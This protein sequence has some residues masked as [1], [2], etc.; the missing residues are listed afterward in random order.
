MLYLYN[1]PKVPFCKIKHCKKKNN[2]NK[3]GPKKLHYE[4]GKLDVS[5]VNE[6]FITEEMKQAEHSYPNPPRTSLHPAH[7]FSVFLLLHISYTWDQVRPKQPCA[8][9]HS[10]LR[11]DF[12][13]CL[14][15]KP[16]ASS[17]G[18]RTLLH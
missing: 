1:F 15:S 17:H 18:A 16:P 5:T 6:K 13:S 8:A 3:S 14:C 11:G 10:H 12:N 9:G 4:T 2:N 7:C